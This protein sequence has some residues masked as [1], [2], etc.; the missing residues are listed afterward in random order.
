M[1][2]SAPPSLYN[3][4]YLFQTSKRVTKR[5]RGCFV[6]YEFYIDVFFV[7]NLLMDYLLLSLTEKL[8][9][10]TAESFRRLFGAA[11]GAGC[12]CLFVLFTGGIHRKGSVIFYCFTAALMVYAEGCHRG[13]KKFIYAVAAFF[14]SSFLLGGILYAIPLQS[15][16]SIW[17]YTIITVTAY[18]IINTGIRLFKHLNGKRGVDCQAVVTFNGRKMKVK[19]LY[20]TGNR[21]TDYDTG[22]PVSIMEYS[23]FIQ[24]LEAKQREVLDR[25]CSMAGSKTEELQDEMLTFLHP[26]FL[27]YRSVGCSQGMLP[28]ITVD[29]LTIQTKDTDREIK[30]A[31]IG[32]SKTAL[33]GHGNFQIIISPTILDS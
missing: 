33:S 26:R 13:G 27:I 9:G 12:T 16:K 29:S 18:L 17:E 8:L 19:G 32:L 15:N 6:Y 10:E 2:K 1:T 24:L 7:V 30:N 4:P 3:E 14:V 21:L 28:V 25:F 20:D 5:F 22:K 31:V 11:L 23:S